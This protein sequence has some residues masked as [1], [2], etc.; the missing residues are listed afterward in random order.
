MREKSL[1]LLKQF[2]K[3]ENLLRHALAV[4]AVMKKLCWYFNQEKELENW[5]MAGLLHDLDWEITKN[6]PEEHGKKAASI[7]KKNGYD[8]R[9]IRAVKAHNHTLKISLENLME[10]TLF[11]VEELTGLI[12][13]CALVN[14]N[15]LA[16]VKADSVKKKFKQSSFAKGVNR[17]LIAQ[18]QQLIGL[19][20]DE[21]TSL[22]LEA[23]KGIKDDLNL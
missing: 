15:K 18:S 22:A 9:I 20:F 21:L 16:G 4:E 1:I 10:K 14:P 2:I 6:C 12:T 5:A 7:L 17:D 8:A 19:S 23:M 11:C 13:A 3:N